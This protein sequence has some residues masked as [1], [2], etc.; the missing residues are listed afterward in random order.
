MGEFYHVLKKTL[1]NL[2][3]KLNIF[4]NQI[5]L[6]KYDILSLSLN[7]VVVIIKEK[8]NKCQE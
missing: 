5:E 1:Y 4:K 6:P 3:F 2:K 8:V 7:F